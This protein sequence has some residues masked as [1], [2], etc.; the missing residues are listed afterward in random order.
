[1][2]IDRQD[3]GSFRSSVIQSIGTKQPCVVLA[4]V[5]AKDVTIDAEPETA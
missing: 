2:M 1:M 5:I 4:V 3:C